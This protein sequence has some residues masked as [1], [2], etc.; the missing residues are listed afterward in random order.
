[1]PTFDHDV[2]TVLRE[3][4]DPPC[5]SLYQ[6]THRHHPENQQDPIRYGNLLKELEASLKKAYPTQKIEPLLKPFRS[7]ANDRAFWR[8]THDG[9][10]ILGAQGVFRVFRLQRSVPE[11]VVVA[12]SFHTK[13]LIRIQQTTDRFQVLGVSRQAIRLF[14]GNRDALD[15]IEP[16]E[17]VPRTIEDALGDE[18]TEPHL[19]VAAYGGKGAATGTMYHGHGGK[20]SEVD[21][22]A[23][24]F[25][26][27][28]DRAVH[29]HHSQP[30]GLPLILAALP[31]HHAT[32]H[33]VS[34]NP[35]LVEDGI[36]AHPDALT[37]DELRERA[38]RV[39]E[40]RYRA[41]IAGLVDEFGA[42]RA[43]GLGDDDIGRVAEAVVTGR[44]GTLLVEA[45]RV[46]PGR[47]DAS[48]GAIEPADLA[49]PAVDDVL[50]DLI[51]EGMK[52]GARILVVP[53]EQM[54]TETGLAAIFRY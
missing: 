52:T 18:L 14:E 9:L 21:L 6:P 4:P 20:E 48:T 53:Q 32:F 28:V 22:D 11:L 50:D 39:V 16:A 36:D 33:A 15:E 7:L 49:H 38:W 37:L 34:H 3:T 19:T 45:D 27:A 5:L 43:K 17:G 47:V 42:A 26:R 25:F 46:V 12:D 10:A 35:M 31:E 40:P 23:E 51:V 1:V 13:P 8:H 44:V 29:E 41:R 2:A 30:T 54:P 24:R